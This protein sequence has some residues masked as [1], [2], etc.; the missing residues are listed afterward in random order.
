MYR[1]RCYTH[2]SKC[3]ACE[4]VFG[5]TFADVLLTLQV[6]TYS[7]IIISYNGHCVVSTSR[8]ERCTTSILMQQLLHDFH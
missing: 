8:T 5:H 3:E 1:N 2:C 7:Y 6:L 4:L